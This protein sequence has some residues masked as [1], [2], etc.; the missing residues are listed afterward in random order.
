MRNGRF[1]RIRGRALAVVLAL[2]TLQLGSLVAPAYACGCGAMVPD[3]QRHMT[4]NR[5]VS[6]VRWDGR[7]EQI[8]GGPPA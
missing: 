5:E 1:G 8:D 2:L 3:D 6:A 4:V 7:Q